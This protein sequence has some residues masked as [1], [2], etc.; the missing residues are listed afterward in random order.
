MWKKIDRECASAAL[1]DQADA[2]NM[3]RKTSTALCR[4]LLLLT[5]VTVHGASWFVLV[6]SRLPKP[7]NLDSIFL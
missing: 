7:A 6:Y 3:Q 5:Q 2:A 1:T 4:L